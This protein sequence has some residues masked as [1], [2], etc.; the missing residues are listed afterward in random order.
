M[1][2]LTFLISLLCLAFSVSAQNQN[3][4]EDSIG[5]FNGFQRTKRNY[6]DSAIKYMQKLAA[7]RPNEA[8]ELLHDSFAQSFLNILQEKMTSDTAFLAMIKQKN[9]TIDSVLSEL[10]ASKKSDYI[11]LSKLSNDNSLFIK[12]NIYPIAE[13]VDAQNNKKNPDKLLEIANRYLKYLAGSNDLYAQRKARYGLLISQLMANHEQL[14]PTSDKI[15]QLIY[16]NLQDQQVTEG[17]SELSRP[18][19]EKRAW[20][21]YMFAYTNFISSQNTNQNKDN[22]VAFLKLAYQYSPDN[23]DKNVSH[24]YFY[25]MIFLLGG[26]KK[27]FEEDYLAA[28]GNDDEKFKILIAISMNDP[29]FKAKAKTL[30]KDQAKFNEYWLNEFNKNFKMAPL[31]SLTQIDGKPYT[32]SSEKN[33]W[34]LIDFWGTWCSPCREEHPALQKLYQRTKDGQIPK[35]NIITIASSDSEPNVKA[36]MQKFNYSFPVVMS[37]NMIE[38]SYNVASWPSKFLISPQ[39][40]LVIIPFNV[41]WEKYIEEYIN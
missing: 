41:N 4:Q 21:R 15:L 39:G 28:L 27:S 37:D 1:K 5:D 3:T 10:K 9:I 38:K 16:N 2:K 36:Y 31:F 24:A 26:E 34:T 23:M 18:L 12:N 40:K 19:K 20:Y 25:D 33:Q 14:K 30:Y 22:K 13:W 7:N 6:P 8:E 35:L 11:I 17:L 32:L 29:S